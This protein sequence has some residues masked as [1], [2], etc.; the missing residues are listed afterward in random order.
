[1][2]SCWKGC[3]RRSKL[4]NFLCLPTMVVSRIFR[5]I[6]TDCP[7]FEMTAR[8]W[9]YLI[10]MTAGIQNV[11]SSTVFILDSKFC[12]LFFIFKTKNKKGDTM[13]HL[14]FYFSIKTMEL[15]TGRTMIQVITS[16]TWASSSSRVTE[17]PQN[18]LFCK[19]VFFW[20][21]RVFKSYSVSYSPP[22]SEN[23]FF[24]S[25]FLLI[26]AYKTQRREFRRPLLKSVL[27]NSY[28]MYC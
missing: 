7:E 1:M 21:I 19:I 24:F 6:L 23:I 3:F 26:V 22:F 18:P 10:T 11:I 27:L 15:V 13:K 28:C 17:T 16:F 5:H 25:F 2:K 20:K 14:W 9:N 12:L 4:Q 8:K